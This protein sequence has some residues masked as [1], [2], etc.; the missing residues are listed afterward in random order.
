M[1]AFLEAHRGSLTDDL[2]EGTG[3]GP[4]P[5][6]LLTP[7]AGGVSGGRAPPG[8]SARQ[9]LSPGGGMGRAGELG[10]SGSGPA[11]SARISLSRRRL[12]MPWCSYKLRAYPSLEQDL[13][14]W[15]GF[16]RLSS[17]AWNAYRPRRTL[18]PRPLI[19]ASTNPNLCH[20]RPMAP[21][22]RLLGELGVPSWG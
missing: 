7:E 11:S 14:H 18:Q 19:R 16:T 9:A 15:L 4:F 2:P 5:M 10:A 3:A 6:A 1:G 12:S 20:H 21:E 17:S 22:S 13:I 8:H